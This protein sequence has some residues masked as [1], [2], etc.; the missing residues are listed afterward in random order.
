MT[1]VDTDVMFKIIK[2]QNGEAVAKVLRDNILLDIPNLAHILEFAGNDPEKIEALVPAIR[3]VYKKQQ[4]SVYK[5][6][7]DPIKLLDDAGYNA[8]VVKTQEDKNSIEKYYRT[9]EKLCTFRDPARHKNYYIIHAVKKNV[10]DIKPSEHPEREDEYGTSVISIQ[11]A[12]GGGFISI[13]NRYNHTVND[14]D[15]TF[16]SNPDNII[17]GLLNALKEYFHVDFNISNVPLPSNYRMVNDQFVYFNYEIENVYFGPDYYF[18][19][20]MITKLNKDYEIM[21]DYFVLNTKTGDVKAIVESEKGTAKIIQSLFKG[22]ND[23]K[24]IKVSINPNNKQERIISVND[25]HVLSVENGIITELNLQDVKQI[26]DN[27]L[28]YNENIRN[29]YAPKLE[30]VGDCFLQ[31]N[32]EL[33]EL[34]FPSLKIISK[35]FVSRNEKISKFFAPFLER[36]GES[37]LSFNK[38]LT[39]LSLPTL[40]EVDSFFLSCNEKIAKFN[41]PCLE[42]VMDGFLHDNKELTELK[43]PALKS[44]GY[45]F[46]CDNKVLT[47]FD[48]PHL[49]QIGGCFLSTNE[50]LTELKLPNVEQIADRFLGF[51]KKLKQLFVPRLKYVGDCFLCA[52]EG[53]TELNLPSLKKVVDFFVKDN[54]QISVF[55]APC[56]EQVGESFLRNNKGLIELDLPSLKVVGHMFISQN[57][58]IS[59]FNAKNL[60]Q[61]GDGFLYNNKCLTELNL[62]SL[63]DVDKCFNLEDKPNL[64]K[65]N[66]GFLTKKQIA[67]ILANNKIEKNLKN[68][69]S[70]M[71]NASLDTYHE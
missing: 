11:V 28:K 33:T 49:E 51:N 15:N 12:K 16:N 68:T 10:D 8:F 21:L 23:L 9:D 3:E 6:D 56:L 2:K 63:K 62:P 61:I 46:L 45:G 65:A 70:V 39:E 53:L 29:V 30:Y 40:K 42:Y 69:V 36:V 17:P 55:I 24:K 4:A 44:V 27:F 66:V 35:S 5:T 14:P 18:F 32:K 71:C 48:A 47:K 60:K 50:G 64:Q 58:Q 1:E 52:N 26:G 19:G 41:A 20:S 59:K 13:K 37:S 43:L 54:E 25:V 22:K 57:K 67:L 38:G 34:D 7:K 31:C